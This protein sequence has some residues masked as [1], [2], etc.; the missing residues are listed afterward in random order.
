MRE[1][2]VMRFLLFDEVESTN[3]FMAQRLAQGD[4]IGGLVVSTDF[5]TRGRGQ[6][7]NVWQSERGANLLFS[8]GLDVG[9]IKAAEQFRLSQAVSV[10]IAEALQ[11]HLPEKGISIKWPNDIYFGDRKMAGIL[12]S[13]TLNGDMMCRSVVGVGIN[14]NQTVFDPSLPNPVS[15]AAVAGHVFDRAAVLNEVTASIASAQGQNAVN[16][17]YISLSYRFG[18]WDKYEFGGNV[19]ELM[20]VGF[21][22]W[23]LLQAVDRAGAKHE[24]DLKQIRFV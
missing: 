22:Q 7:S 17:R 21:S 6:G 18:K 14:V 11:K 23:G 3:V 16:D 1:I 12:I 5:Q 10:G 20:I 15:M 24:F 19:R 2:E 9:F 13:N 4:D 8:I